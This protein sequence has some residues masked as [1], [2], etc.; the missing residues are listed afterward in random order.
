[1]ILGGYK[2]PLRPVAGGVAG[3]PKSF[4]RS[5]YTASAHAPIPSTNWRSRL[6]GRYEVASFRNMGRSSSEAA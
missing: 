6:Q 5:S 4:D 1:M 3:N 2:K